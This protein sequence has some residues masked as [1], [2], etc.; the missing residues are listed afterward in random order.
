[1]TAMIT[2]FL[3]HVAHDLF[4]KT[5][6]ETGRIAVVFPNKRAGLFFSEYLAREAGRPVWA[7]AYISISE[8]FRQASPLQVADPVK[9]VC[10]LYRVF[11]TVTGSTERADDFYFWGELLLADFDD[12]DKNLVQT[13]TLFSNLRALN[14]LT[15]RYEFLE[16]GQREALEHF[17]RSF[18]IERLTELKQRFMTLWDVLGDIY[19]G[20]RQ[21]LLEQGLAYEGMLYRS[22][23]E[24]LDPS[25]LPYEKY[26]L[27][28]FNVLNKVEQQLFTKLQQAGK[29]WFYW[30][31][32]V[33]YL[34]RHPHEAG[35]FIR[36]N[37]RQ[38]PSELPSELFDSLG[39]P[40][41]V[42]FVES[43]T[44]NGQARYLPQWIRQNLTEEEKDTAV[45][46][47]N[48]SL[49]QA[50]LHALPENIRH[51]NITMGFP[52]SQTPAY[53][54][55][56]TLLALHT[57]G[58][59]PASGRFL[60]EQ[61]TGV[62]KHPYTRLLSAQADR[63]LETLCRN[64]RFYPLPAE[65]QT[66]DALS[67]LFTPCR[68]NAALCRLLVMALERVAAIYSSRT[69]ASH[70][71]FDQLYREALF[72]TYTLTNRFVTLIEQGDL[73]VQTDTLRR[74]LTRVLST[75]GIPF[76]GEP[77]IGLQI[78]GV[79]ETRNLDFRHLVM[80]SVNEGFLPKAGGD[81]SFIP[82][83]LR[84]AFGMTT[85][86]HKIAVYAYY[87]YRLLQRAERVTLVYNTATDG[88]NRGEWSRFML[89]FLTEW[90]HPVQ[91]C[92]LETSQT[93]AGPITLRIDKTQR[94]QER[95]RSLFDIRSNQQALLSPSALNCYLDCPLKFYFRHVAG[96]R[97]P[98][99]VTAQI[100]PATFGNIFH[101]VAEQLYKK[102]T[103]HG[104]TVTASDLET[105]LQDKTL[106]EDEVDRGFKKLF[107]NVSPDT[108]PE[109]NGVQLL[110]AAVIT[111]YIR[112]LLKNDL[113][114][115]PFDFLASEMRIAE[116]VEILAS[117]GSVH[118]RIG[119]IIDR[120]D[121]KGEVVRI[122]D[123]KTGGK[124][125]VPD[126]VDALFS[127]DESHAGHVFQTFLYASIVLRKMKNEGKKERLSPALLY[128]RQT[129]SDDYS[130][131]I[132]IRGENRKKE[133]VDDFSVYDEEFRS[134]LDALLQQI[135]D[136][137]RPFLQTTVQ[138]VCTYCD[139]KDLCRR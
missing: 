68:D 90:G 127:T 2:P 74:L 84:K 3:Q 79:L 122:V 5:K 106:L 14:D 57:E 32:D 7:P 135:F 51:T 76:H 64:N 28:G 45:V 41:E 55:A 117:G 78:M 123:Y 6:G 58:Y 43:A 23:I 120:M 111:R 10:D 4:L 126:G 82:Y 88:L 110:N 139:F 81:A 101:H 16:E 105:V 61:V 128:I 42:T 20:F 119:G 85:I 124:A 125:E 24:D 21:R 67:L 116:E 22:V 8:L 75:A 17:F 48:E 136:P 134:H 27:V 11:T 104:C 115:A 138:E 31:Y 70:E 9:L 100:D 30:D 92:C 63:L 66:D 96:L 118:T 12:A 65:L 53:S 18:S 73:P 132:E 26:A 97:S 87:F 25:D 109:Y 37:L 77:A 47:C 131:V 95:M 50:V 19:T 35:E 103:R 39:K 102:L 107:F 15:D 133:V 54:F 89:Q 80:L 86:D 62:L 83:N 98:N 33:F 129:A 38:F 93:P 114:Y 29:A 69:A 40:K 44:E 91:R 94:V 71:A 137:D 46:L 52:L 49:L 13:E 112:Q 56:D 59:N 36:R 108:K 60:F 113:R 121:R 72:R 130:P 1:M 34:S 99:E